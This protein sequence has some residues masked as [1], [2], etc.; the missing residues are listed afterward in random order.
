[1]WSL[2]QFGEIVAIEVVL[3]DLKMFRDLVDGLA[4]T[5]Q[6]QGS[7][8]VFLGEATKARQ[9]LAPG[10]IRRNIKATGM[11]GH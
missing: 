3:H 4:D 7:G 10:N 11:V 9:L 5:G 6:V 1:M 2:A 8:D